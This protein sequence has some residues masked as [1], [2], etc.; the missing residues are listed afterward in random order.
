MT[1]QKFAAGKPLTFW[2]TKDYE[3]LSDEAIIEGVLEYGEF[4]DVKKVISI[5]GREKTA[6]IFYNKVKLSRHNFDP[7]VEN[8]FNLYFKHASRNPNR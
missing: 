2:S 1:L 5:I 6:E 3:S 8:Y 7:K 4:D